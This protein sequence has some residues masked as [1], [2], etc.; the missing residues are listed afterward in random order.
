MR[1]LLPELKPEET[2]YQPHQLTADVWRGVT[3]PY[4]SVT[5][6]IAR[7]D[8]QKTYISGYISGRTDSGSG[9]DGKG[10]RIVSAQ[11]FSSMIWK[12]SNTPNANKLANNSADLL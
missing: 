3:A 8:C 4:G 5:Q 1:Y 12:R 9:S 2:A 7:H 10:P 11:P 6:G